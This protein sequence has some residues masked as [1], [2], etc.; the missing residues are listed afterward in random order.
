MNPSAASPHPPAADG[1]A[2]GDTTGTYRALVFG[3]ADEA[4][5]MGAALRRLGVEV[6]VADDRD[7]TATRVR[8]ILTAFPADVVVPVGGAYDDAVLAALGEPAVAG[9]PAPRMA[10]SMH[11]VYVAGRRD[12]QLRY[13]SSELGVPV[14]R[15]TVA[16]SPAE[17]ERAAAALGYPVCISPVRSHTGARSV[18]DAP[19]D[20]AA[21]FGRAG[22][23]T[24]VVEH[25]IEA[26]VEVLMLTVTSADPA[27]PRRDVISFCEPI[28]FTRH[29]DGRVATAWQ[30]QTTTEGEYDAARSVAARVVRG[31]GG[32]GVFAVRL[33]VRSGDVYF[34]GVD[35]GPA[36][37]GVLTVRSQVL[38]QWALHA[39]AVLGAPC[40]ATMS[41]PAAAVSCCHAVA[42]G[43]I[44]GVL[45][46]P[47]TTLWLCEETYAFS[48]WQHGAIIASA[49]TV[50]QARQ[51]AAAAADR[52]SR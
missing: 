35:C 51:R 39:R 48:P 30:P 16:A 49:D 19:V 8:D 52:A 4:E 32:R 23:A 47:E 1:T 50:E 41:S 17:A 33:L 46:V 24:A 36:A 18:V 22:S 38:D 10:P 27:Q 13:A 21:A 43:D 25:H 26:D 9:V 40:E 3:A 45:A 11:A 7:L 29:P 12:L 5:E 37:A 15:Y 42:T 34:S 44:P 20:V 2:G 6:A 14:A 31:L 28:G